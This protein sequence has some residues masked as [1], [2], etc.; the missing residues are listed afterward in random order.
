MSERTEI[1]NR[2]RTDPS[3]PRVLLFSSVL[4]AGVNLAVASSII[5]MDQPWSAQDER[6]IIGRL[7]RQPQS[8]TVYAY[9]LR[10]F[11][12]TDILMTSM[13]RGK[14]SLLET[15]SGTALLD[16]LM[17][18][19]NEREERDGADD[20]VDE[21]KSLKKKAT[22]KKKPH[23]KSSKSSRSGK[24]IKKMGKETVR[25]V[26]EEV[27]SEENRIVTDGKPDDGH[28]VPNDC[29]DSTAL[30]KH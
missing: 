10:A 29:V 11:G 27:L 3:S 21:Q 23:E 15:F 9:S 22:A 17:G 1:I 26:D 19:A 24:S 7:W 20:A 5:L 13:A 16:G 2:F 18:V 30:A 12:T 4:A 14:A 25:T 28:E 6:Q 8:N